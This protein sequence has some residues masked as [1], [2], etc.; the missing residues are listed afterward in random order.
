MKHSKVALATAALAAAAVAVPALPGAALPA[1]NASTGGTEVGI[2]TD[3]TVGTAPAEATTTP[4]TTPTPAPSPGSAESAPPS[5]P[6]AG[7]GSGNPGDVLAPGEATP[8]GVD[9]PGTSGTEDQRVLTLAAAQRLAG[10]VLQDCERRGFQVTVSVVDR[11]G[12]EVVTLRDEDA[13]GATVA[14]ATGKAFAAAGFQTPTAV[15]QEAARTSPGFTT[16]PGFVLLP[17]GQPVRS[18]GTT[19]GGIGV[20]GAPSG[21]IDDACI[22]VGFASV[23]DALG[24][25]EPAGPA[26][27]PPAPAPPLPAPPAPSAPSAPPAPQSPAP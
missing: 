7:S 11:D 3:V 26:P 2:G 1:G 16:V 23:R 15:L 9:L 19:V 4:A 24:P 25:V 18:G 13:T 14:T 20:S 17:G 22:N 10:A 5:P 12:I 27:A 21:E 8:R 6:P